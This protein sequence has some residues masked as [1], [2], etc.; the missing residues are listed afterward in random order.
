MR[1]QGSTTDASLPAKRSSSWLSPFLTQINQAGEG[2]TAR[3]GRIASG[4]GLALGQAYTKSVFEGRALAHADM[5]FSVKGYLQGELSLSSRPLGA[6]GLTVGG[7]F[8][9]TDLAQED[10]FGFGQ[11]SSA[12]MHTS[13]SDRMTDVSLITSLSPRG[14][15]EIEGT[16][17]FLNHDI[18]RGRQSGVPSIEERFTAQAVPG[19]DASAQ[20]IQTGVAAVVDLRDVAEAPR[21]GGWYRAS[22]THYEGMSGNGASFGAFEADLRQFIAVPGTS[23]HVLALRGQIASTVGGGDAEIPFFMMPR[24][25]GSS[26]RGYEISRY[27]DRHLLA[28]SVEHRWDVHPKLQLVGFVDAGQVAPAFGHFGLERFQSSVGMGVRYRVG[29]HAALRLDVAAGSEGPRWHIGFG[30][31]F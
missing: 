3:A 23:T 22:L 29:G 11:A 21:H 25:G 27:T 31:S 13:Y 16:A 6:S 7:R 5:L 28:F 18:G 4:G 19:L 12:S 9:Y 20:F 14:W 10:F 24:L 17:G 1:Q 15:L 26:L 30:P 2:W 8:R